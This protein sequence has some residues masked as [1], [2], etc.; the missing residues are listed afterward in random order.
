MRWSWA[1]RCG[2]PAP[3]LPFLPLQAPRGGGGHPTGTARQGSRWKLSLPSWA[4]DAKC[5]F[6]G[7]AAVRG[8]SFCEPLAFLPPRAERRLPQ[9]PPSPARVGPRF[10]SQP[11]RL[12]PRAFGVAVRLGV[13]QMHPPAFG[14]AGV[15]LPVMPGSY[16]LASAAALGFGTRVPRS[17]ER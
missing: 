2:S 6:S 14:A 16:S 13:S 5:A 12:Q 11:P 8:C 9:E 7:K 15:V 3:R 4:S 17:G 10:C 1:T